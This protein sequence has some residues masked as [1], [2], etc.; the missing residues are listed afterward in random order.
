IEAFGPEK[1]T[2]RF[3]CR[4]GLGRV[5]CRGRGTG[6]ARRGGDVARS[7]VRRLPAHRGA[8]AAQASVELVAVGSYQR[9]AADLVEQGVEP[10][11]DRYDAEPVGDAGPTDEQLPLGRPVADAEHLAVLRTNAHGRERDTHVVRRL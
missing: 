3:T 5:R 11:T 6:R 4:R 10:L 9:A 1:G 8:D 7:R 2:R